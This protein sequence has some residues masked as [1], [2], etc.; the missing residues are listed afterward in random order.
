MIAC[1]GR[2]VLLPFLILLFGFRG[3]EEE[4]ITRSFFTNPLLPSGPDPW[5]LQKDGWYYF[6]HTT[7]KDLR[8]YRTKR[9]SDLR[10]ADMKIIWTP[11]STGMNSKEIWAPE[12]H[13]MEGRWYFYYAADDGDNKN[14]R[15]WVLENEARDPFT[16]NWADKGELKL[17]GDKWAIDGTVF[18]HNGRLYF[19][20]SGWEGD[21][22]L[23]QD[24]YIAE[25]ADPMT[26]EGDRVLLSKPEYDWEL[27]GGS[28]AIN[29]AP[30]FLARGDKIF[31]IYS[32]SGCWTDDYALGLLYAPATANLLD[33][34]SWIKHPEPLF[35]KAPSAQAFGPGHNSF[36]K[37]PNGKEDWI[38]Y[39]ANPEAGQGCRGNRS[40]RMQPFGWT[41]D[42]LP[43]LG[44]PVALETALEVPS[45]EE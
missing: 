9:M 14:H 7:G 12:I 30:Q 19:T 4:R 16:G 13:F 34:S 41:Q 32:A 21:V 28:P 29:E 10:N 26:V 31:I 5:V 8:L 6:T 23:R 1:C 2:H 45:G 40:P 15:M 42:G 22:N 38:L 33:A 18:Q 25:M 3:G 39:H 27:K 36:F 11:P 20:W 24:I 17:P 37:S 35:Q 44:K 43:A